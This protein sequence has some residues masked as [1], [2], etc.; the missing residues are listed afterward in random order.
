MTAV[1]VVTAFAAGALF[2]LAA[3][4]QQQMAATR[5]AGEQLSW[6]LIVHLARERTWLLGIAVATGSYVLQAVA[7]SLA[8]LSVVQ[9]LL[10][11]E[12]IFAVP[13]SVH[14]HHMR[15]HRR[16]WASIFAVTAAL[17]AGLAAAAPQPGHPLVSAS[18]WAPI[19][20]ISLGL[21]ALT[22]SLGRLGHGRARAAA[23]AVAAAVLT[24]VE[25]SLMAATAAN[26]AHGPGT[27]FT[28]WETYAMAAS[29]IGVLLLMQSAFQA[30]P[31]AVS[32]P[33]TDAL[34]P[35]VAIV[36][37]VTL[38]GEHLNSSPVHITI[39]T[40]AA[41]VLIASIVAL[42]IS[43]VVQA[44]HRAESRSGADRTGENGCQP[45]AALTNFRTSSV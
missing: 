35:A 36:I 34:S 3:V 5:P 26:F 38:F 30:G 18:S 31:L 29:S 7:L 1:G 2:A 14:R 45:G 42:D 4:L 43:P 39:A 40:V 33:I 28:A 9:P 10:T 17:A 13:L 32:L 21:V 37:G 22:V 27:G 44:V 19:L 16:E 6:R 11:A 25:S 8:P 15:L 12:V 20:G 24:G 41:V 23:Y